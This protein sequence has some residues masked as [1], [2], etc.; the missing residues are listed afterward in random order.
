MYKDNKNYKNG[1]IH[2][3]SIVA[4]NEK[5]KR[6]II[7]RKDDK[8]YYLID[9]FLDC[10]EDS[11]AKDFIALL[12]RREG[13][14]FVHEYKNIYD[15]NK[16]AV[17]SKDPVKLGYVPCVI[18]SFLVKKIKLG[19]KLRAYIKNVNTDF[20]IPNELRIEARVFIEK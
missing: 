16:I 19:K 2:K 6:I 15:P 18:A 1:I 12:S 3:T 7:E 8:P 14:E 9:F 10:Y 5:F 13:L 4:H 17:Y 20:G 11:D